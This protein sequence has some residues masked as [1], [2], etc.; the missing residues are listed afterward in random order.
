MFI[1]YLGTA[2]N[3]QEK[4]GEAVMNFEN[5]ISIDPNYK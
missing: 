1:T 3:G 2:L 4:F 5:A